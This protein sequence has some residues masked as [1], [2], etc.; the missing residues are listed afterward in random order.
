MSNTEPGSRL[1]GP[2]A[3]VHAQLL[4]LSGPD[5][6]TSADL[7]GSA[8]VGRS[9]AGK[10]LATLEKAGLAIRTPG[11]RNG[12]VRTPDL[13]RAA[14]A[15]EQAAPAA[16][17]EQPGTEP[18]QPAAPLDNNATAP[19]DQPAAQTAETPDDG[20][21][22]PVS[23]D[24]SAPGTEAPSN[25]D[26]DDEVRPDEVQSAQIIEPHPAPPLNGTT[27]SAMKTRLAPG[28]LRD[29]VAA[30]LRAHPGEAFT[31]TRI[32]RLIDKSSGAITNALLTL[33]KQGIATQ[34][35]ERPRTYR[36]TSPEDNR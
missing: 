4:A 28:C 17:P 14:P 34:V 35:T 15:P 23:D 8:G 24:G 33:E 36:L 32:S 18:R 10:A 6:A 9:T 20:A 30:H 3:A 13:W 25:T 26:L 2:P 19:S 11:S 16:H 31:A 1:T 22:G 7:A 29:M 21:T 27:P 5:G 12:S